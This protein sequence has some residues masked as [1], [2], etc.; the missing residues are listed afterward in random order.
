MKIAAE[1]AEDADMIVEEVN[2]EMRDIF[3]DQIL[4]ILRTKEFLEIQNPEN[5]IKLKE[6]LK[7]VLNQLYYERKGRKDAID[8]ILFTRWE[9]R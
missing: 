9:I 5:E 4:S 6:E 3:R 7:T 2:E 1:K 8:R